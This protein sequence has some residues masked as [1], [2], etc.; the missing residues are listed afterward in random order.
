MIVPEFHKLL[1]YGFGAF[2]LTVASI[3]TKDEGYLKT[4]LV[5]TLRHQ[6]WEWSLSDICRCMNLGNLFTQGHDC[7]FTTQRLSYLTV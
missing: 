5:K 4:G 6:S 2:V 7:N 1:D 3:A